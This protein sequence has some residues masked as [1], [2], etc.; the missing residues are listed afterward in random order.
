MGLTISSVVQYISI[1]Q[2]QLVDSVS[3]L[4]K[5]SRDIDE[6]PNQS[7]IQSICVCSSISVF[8]YCTRRGLK[9]GRGLLTHQNRDN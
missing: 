6:L 1:G 9:F 7:H 8:R 2:I 5:A 3:S 4:Y